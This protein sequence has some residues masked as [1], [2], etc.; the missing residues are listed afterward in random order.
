MTLIAKPG[1]SAATQ[2]V[3][4]AQRMVV[5][6][7]RKDRSEAIDMALTFARSIDGVRVE[8]ARNGWYAIMVGPTTAKTIAE[9]Q[10]QMGSRLYLPSDAYVGR[11]DGFQEQTF[12][13]PPSPVRAVVDYRGNDRPATIRNGPLS[14]T[15]ESTQGP[16]GC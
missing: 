11:L 15:L 4:A 16:A 6:A 3:D 8:L 12:E 9:A 1:A 2:D 10:R 13:A 7:A 14:V 5:L